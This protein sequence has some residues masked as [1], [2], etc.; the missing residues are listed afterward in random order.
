[1]SSS[2]PDSKIDLLDS[3]EIVKKKLKKAVSLQHVSYHSFSFLHYNLGLVVSCSVQF[4]GLLY[5][6]HFECALTCLPGRCPQGR[7]G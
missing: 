5:S 7:R 3:P 4:L 6:Y 1:M 2:D